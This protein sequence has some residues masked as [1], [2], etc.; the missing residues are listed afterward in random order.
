M[1]FHLFRERQIVENDSEKEKSLHI[2]I[3]Q[4]LIVLKLTLPFSLKCSFLG[5]FALSLC[6]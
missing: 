3:L 6:V 4:F 5:N 1:I 2:N